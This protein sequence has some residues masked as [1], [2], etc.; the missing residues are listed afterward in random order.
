MNKTLQAMLHTL[1]NRSPELVLNGNSILLCPFLHHLNDLFN[2]WIGCVLE[3]LDN[4]GQGLSFFPPSDD[5]LPMTNAG[6]TFSFPIFRVWIQPLQHVEGFGRV[7]ELSHFV[8]IIGNQLEKGKGFS[9]CL[10]LQVQL[11]S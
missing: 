3:H 5:H 7:K 11:P 10:H 2:L 1:K 6:T 9:A 8:A 4:I